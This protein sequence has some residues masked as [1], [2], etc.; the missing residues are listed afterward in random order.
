MIFDYS[1]LDEKGSLRV[2]FSNKE[3]GI[4]AL[5]IDLSMLR[6]LTTCRVLNVQLG[7]RGRKL[8]PF[9]NLLAF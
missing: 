4:N 6:I 2:Y 3:N 5:K 1:C 9:G 8:L 7:Y